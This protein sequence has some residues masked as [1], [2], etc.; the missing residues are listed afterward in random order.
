MPE[1]LKESIIVSI[2]DTLDCYQLDCTD[3]IVDLRNINDGLECVV[4]MVAGV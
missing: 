1:A 4:Y 3:G 2:C